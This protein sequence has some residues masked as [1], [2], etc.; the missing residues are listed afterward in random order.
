MKLQGEKMT[1]ECSCKRLLNKGE[2]ARIK[3]ELMSQVSDV[4]EHK[5][6]TS[7]QASQHAFRQQLIEYPPHRA[8]LLAN[9]QPV[10][11]TTK[12]TL[13][14]RKPALSS[15]QTNGHSSK[16][17]SKQTLNKSCNEAYQKLLIEFRPC[18]ENNQTNH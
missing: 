16:Q 3:C 9:S 1:R 12:E 6:R 10:R 5:Q 15:K 8:Q 18:E 17:T 11:H 7:M 13:C 14:A 2:R 4:R